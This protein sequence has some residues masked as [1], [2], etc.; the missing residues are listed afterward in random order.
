MSFGLAVTIGVKVKAAPQNLPVLP[1]IVGA[2]VPIYPPAAL[3]T[4]TQGTIHIAVT[5]NGDRI[6]IARAQESLRPLSEEAERNAKTWTFRSHD[7]TEFTITYKFELSEACGV[8]N[9]TVTMRFPT[10]VEIC[11]H[12]EKFY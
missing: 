8:N 2:S 6:V 11:Q 10:E 12:P 4:N 5:T 7:A 3:L 1:I 9:P